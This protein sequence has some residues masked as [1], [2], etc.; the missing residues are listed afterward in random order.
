MNFI[1]PRAEPLI[2]E[3]PLSRLALAPENVR[4]TP[5]DPRADAELKASIAALGLLENLVVRADEPGEDGTDRYAVVAGGRRLRAMQAL[6]ED[7]VLD[8]DHP[9]PCQVRSGDAEPGEI[10]LAENV[11]RVP[12]HPADQV[13][14][15]TRLAD[16]AAQRVV[17]LRRRPDRAP[18]GVGEG[19]RPLQRFLLKAQ[20][21][22]HFGGRR[23][24]DRL[25]A[26]LLQRLA[27]RL[28]AFRRGLRG[29][30]RGRRRNRLRLLRFLLPVAV[31]MPAKTL[32]H[33]R[34]GLPAP[35]APFRGSRGRTQDRP[36]GRRGEDLFQGPQD[37]ARH[38]CPRR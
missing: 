20:I 19:G 3:I 33:T 10:S 15:F 22:G 30:R 8:A 27:H 9:V 32:S 35:R 38:Y 24:E 2:R 7:N 5:P 18:E 25:G 34:S 29:T 1:A 11:I 12:M 31:E 37:D 36:H 17:E 28:D 16:R 21:G 26:G 23:I 6:V 4:K 14:A 13:V